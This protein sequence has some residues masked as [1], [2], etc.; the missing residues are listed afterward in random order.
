MGFPGVPRNRVLVAGLLGFSPRDRGHDLQKNIDGRGTKMSAG[1]PP[2][3]HHVNKHGLAAGQAVQSRERQPG[4]H[5][6][7]LARPG[8]PAVPP[9]SS[10]PHQEITWCRCGS[11]G[12]F[13][14]PWPGP[15][16]FERAEKPSAVRG[17]LFSQSVSGNIVNQANKAIS[18]KATNPTLMQ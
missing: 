14:L 8:P 7:F 18:V 17:R 5:P 2:K 6:T 12:F 9:P 15:R 4:S 13:I 1:S 11:D 16:S 10:L 3:P